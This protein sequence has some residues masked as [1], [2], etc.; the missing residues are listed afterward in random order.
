MRI[1]VAVLVFALCPLGVVAAKSPAG[2]MAGM[3]AALIAGH[4]SGPLVCSRK[5]ATFQFVGRTTGSGFSIYNYNYLYDPPG[6]SHV[7]HGG[8]RILLFRGKRYVGQYGL[9]SRG[10]LTVHVRGARLVLQSTETKQTAE[11]DLS[12]KPP[13]EVFLA[14][15]FLSFFR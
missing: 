6:G 3:R 13:K 10:S 8:Q 1:K 7:M 14:G 2:C 9:W 5:D 4:F 11:L 12:G 15:D